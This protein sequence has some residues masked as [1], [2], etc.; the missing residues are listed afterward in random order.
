MRFVKWMKDNY[1]LHNYQRSA[2]VMH[3][4]RSVKS[5]MELELLQTAIDITEKG[6]RR[7]LKFIE[8]R[9]VGA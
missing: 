4:L 8:T 9:C 3:Q 5:N 6:L 7:I 1:P 2:P